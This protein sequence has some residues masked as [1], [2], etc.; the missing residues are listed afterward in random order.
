MTTRSTDIRD[1]LPRPLWPENNR[2]G[3]T[4]T[5]ELAEGAE[6]FFTLMEGVAQL[7]AAGR[8][9]KP[10]ARVAQ[11]IEGGRHLFEVREAVEYVG[12]MAHQGRALRAGEHP[13]EPVL[14]IVVDMLW[15]GSS[16]L[17]TVHWLAESDV[18]SLGDAASKI[19]MASGIVIC[20]AAVSEM[21][22]DGYQLAMQLPLEGRL[23]HELLEEPIGTQ[24]QRAL[25][26]AYQI[27]RRDRWLLI[28]NFFKNALYIAGGICSITVF[29]N[30]T[31]YAVLTAGAGG[32]GFYRLWYGGSL[33]RVRV[34]AQAAQQLINDPRIRTDLS[35]GQPRPLEPSAPPP[36]QVSADSQP[37]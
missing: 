21:V 12:E 34:R 27:V 22:G 18:I 37:R 17:E 11:A 32:L 15:L 33:D 25:L 6:S 24:R 35:A 31:F 13:A 8:A 19:G 29:R 20:A 7:T 4:T 10:L 14:D 30:R 5:L 3:L 16:S 1:V 2:Y 28:I 26:M 23:Q 9:A 36:P